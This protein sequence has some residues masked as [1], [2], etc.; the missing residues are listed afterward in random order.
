[1]KKL[2]P[3]ARRRVLLRDLSLNSDDERAYRRLV[4]NA[5]PLAD[6]PVGSI[7]QTLD[8]RWGQ[9]YEV[10]EHV[11]APPRSKGDALVGDRILVKSPRGPGQVGIPTYHVTEVL[12]L[13]GA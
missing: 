9:V 3:A 12:R 10:S 1:M 11:P 13:P 5:F 2:T 4:R 6:M 8:P 7:V